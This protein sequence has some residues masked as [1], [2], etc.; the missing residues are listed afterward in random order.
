MPGFNAQTRFDQG[1]KQVVEHLLSN[2]A[3]QVADPA[4]DAFSDKVV[5][6]MRR[7]EAEISQL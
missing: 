3:L 4:F 1:A 7:A 2:P 5:D 6:I